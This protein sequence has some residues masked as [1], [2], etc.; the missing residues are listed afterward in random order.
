MYIRSFTKEV[1]HIH[2]LQM[3]LKTLS[4][5]T[6]CPPPP[7]NPTKNRGDLDFFF[8]DV[9]YV[10]VFLWQRNILISLPPHECFWPLCLWLVVVS[11]CSYFKGQYT[12][13]TSG[14][15]PPPSTPFLKTQY[16]IYI[17]KNFFIHKWHYCKV[18]LGFFD[19]TCAVFLFFILKIRSERVFNFTLKLLTTHKD[20][21]SHEPTKWTESFCMSTVTSGTFI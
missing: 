20:P 13:M 16:Q 21:Q 19:A 9:R 1:W 2:N 17:G 10:T 8:S 3:A 18:Q 11:A 6:P 7:I 5:L 4:G 15:T 12:T 14:T